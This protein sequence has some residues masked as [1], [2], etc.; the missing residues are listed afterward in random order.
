MKKSSAVD[1]RTKIARMEN[2]RDSAVILLAAG[3]GSRMGLLTQRVPKALLEVGKQPVIDWILGAVLARSAGEI[4]VVLGHGAEMLSDHLAAKYGG[5]VQTVFN[6][7]YREDVN[8]LSVERAV[9]ALVH[10]ERGYLIVETDLLVGERV[11][12]R[13][14]ERMALSLNSF[15]VCHGMYGLQLT[16]GIV[17][18][19]VDGAIDAIDYQPSYCAEFDGWLKMLGILYV[20]PAEVKSDQLLRQAALGNIG[21]YYMAPW[22]THLEVL[23]CRAL[24]VDDGFA[25]SFN[26]SVEFTTAGEAFLAH[27]GAT[28][29]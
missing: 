29:P 26:T 6:E 27:V 2:K 23:P 1:P 9:Q 7:R 18:V 22:I 14:F 25:V 4:V 8:I 20:G 21:Q 16:G 10:P 24:R 28:R 3:R 11:W 15:W 13:I 17:R 12:D 19:D 5:R